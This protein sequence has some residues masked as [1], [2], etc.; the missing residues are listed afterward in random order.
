[1]RRLWSEPVYNIATVGQTSGGTSFD[2][3]NEIFQYQQTKNERFKRSNIRPIK[4]LINLSDALGLKN[5]PTK[6]RCSSGVSPLD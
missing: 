5:R 4:E 1:M 2:I 6:L 3:I